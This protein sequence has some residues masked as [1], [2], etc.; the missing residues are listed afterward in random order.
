MRLV[1]DRKRPRR[2]IP[3]FFRDER[4]VALIFS[5]L[6]VPLILFMAVAT[7]D[8]GLMHVAKANLQAA[9]DAAALA[10]V[11]EG[12]VAKQITVHQAMDTGPDGEIQENVI[13]D[14]AT[15][16]QYKAD[17]FVDLV[18]FSAPARVDPGIPHKNV[19]SNGYP[20]NP[21]WEYRLIDNGYVT[22][23]YEKFTN[24]TRKTKKVRYCARW[25]WVDADGDG[26]DDYEECARWD[27]YYTHDAHA[28]DY[29]DYWYPKLYVVNIIT[30]DK[31][32]RSVLPAIDSQKAHQEAQKVLQLNGE[33]WF[34]T[35][36]GL[37]RNL[38]IEQAEIVCVDPDR[39]HHV[40]VGDG[41]CPNAQYADELNISYR[42]NKASVEVRTIL[43][44]PLTGKGQWVKVEVLPNEATSRFRRN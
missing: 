6:A 38:Q 16:L 7:V 9:I 26:I 39:P 33:S 41:I 3:W 21:T 35:K 30:R 18:K 34:E 8:I 1:Q 22:E 5:A 15:Y 12:T 28:D 31:A 11:R 10:G 19:T 14:H 13:I 37:F 29:T 2:T 27:E 20:A 23:I 32:V 17:N 43:I 42:I 36:A 25:K 40:V 44:G 4:G 24:H